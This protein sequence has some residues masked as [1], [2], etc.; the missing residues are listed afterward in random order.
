MKVNHETRVN[1]HNVPISD[2]TFIALSREGGI[3]A[4]ALD[5]REGK[6]AIEWQM[7]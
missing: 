1:F 5:R 3:E 7:Q 4:A 2:H 6:N